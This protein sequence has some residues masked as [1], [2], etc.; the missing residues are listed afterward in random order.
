MADRSIRLKRILFSILGFFVFLHTGLVIAYYIG[1]ALWGNQIWIVDALGYL[2]PWLFV[3]SLLLLLLAIIS[4]SRVI[5]IAAAIPL[6][7]FVLS[8]GR[9]FLPK[10]SAGETSRSLTVMTYNVLDLNEQYDDVADQITAY[11]PDVLGLH[12][13]E[14]EMARVLEERLGSRY[15]FREIEPGRGLFSRYPIEQYSAFQ[16]A[17]NGHWAQQAVL[18]INGYR[19]TLLNVHP[20][21]PRMRYGTTLGLPSGFFTEKRDRDFTDLISQIANHDGPLIVMGDMNLSDRQ[22][23]YGELREYLLDVHHERGWGLG[24]TRTNYPQIGLPTWRIDYIFYSPEMKAL[25]AEVGEFAGS[26]HRPVI[27]RIGFTEDE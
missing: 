13:L 5:I 3:P 21:S 18:N 9:F 1:H 22:D 27:A 7:L 2:L 14:S 23:Q 10:G 6:L 11:D 26:D 8:Y 15:P 25:T 4:R 20:R 24:F 17:E 19:V 12:E 16:L